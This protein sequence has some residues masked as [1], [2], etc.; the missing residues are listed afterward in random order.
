M[1]Y[2]LWTS[3]SEAQATIL[4]GVLTVIAAG[5]GVLAGAYLFGGKVKNITNAIEHSERLVE[6]HLGQMDDAL[7]KIK[8]KAESLDAVLAAVTE[9][10]SKSAYSSAPADAESDSDADA[11]LEAAGVDEIDDRNLDVFPVGPSRAGIR[12]AWNDIADHL[13][14]IAS[15][16]AIDGR[17]RARYFR[18]DRRSFDDLINALEHDDKISSNVAAAA[19][20]AYALRN[21]LK[22]RH[23]EPTQDEYDRMRD[24]QHTVLAATLKKP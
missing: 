2:G 8:D 24:W 13:N 15:N 17:T 16:P 5:V 22:R 11:G 10:L 3:L 19:R 12:G 1:L 4:N 6:S 18:I 21:S 14:A 23:A 9:Q 7:A 20:E